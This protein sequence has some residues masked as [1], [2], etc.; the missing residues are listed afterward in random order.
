LPTDF[1]DDEKVSRIRPFFSIYG[2]SYKFK[3]GSIY[4]DCKAV[5]LNHL[6]AY[7]KM[8]KL[9]EQSGHKSYM[10]FPLRKTYIPCCMT[11]DTMILSNHI[12]L[13]S[14]R[15]KLDKKLIWG[16]V[17]NLSSKALKDQGESKTMKFQSMIQ[18]DGIGVSVLKQNKESSKGGTKE[19]RMKDE[20]EC[21][22]IN[23]LTTRELQGTTNK[24]VFIDPGR[25]DLLYCMHERSKSNSKRDLYWYTL[26]QRAKETKSR[27]FTKLR[28]NTKPEEVKESEAYLSKHPAS[29][30]NVPQFAEYLKARARV[31]GVVFTL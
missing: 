31:H 9:C 23:R 3:N 4:Y 14:H 22:Y 10:Y 12:I 11:I 24:Y 5:P 16:K 7:Y 30:V 2:S 1:L 8:A 6:M 26:N 15:S 19:M 29:T 13:D 20:D 21:Q 28:Q 25:R 27:K 18:T 17:V